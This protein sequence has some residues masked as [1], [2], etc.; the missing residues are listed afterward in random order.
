M[1]R[2]P[3]DMSLLVTC[4]ALFPFVYPD[5]L[6]KQGKAYRPID[7]APEIQITDRMKILDDQDRKYGLHQIEHVIKSVLL[8]ADEAGYTVDLSK[9][10]FT[11]DQPTVGALSRVIRAFSEEKE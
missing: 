6:V 10:D 3:A 1:A 4:K 11:G 7:N 5:L 9:D 8:F 2:M